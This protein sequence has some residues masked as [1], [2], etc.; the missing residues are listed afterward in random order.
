MIDFTNKEKYKLDGLS[1]EEYA[2]IY[3]TI[4]LFMVKV[5]ERCPNN[6]LNDPSDFF[7][8]WSELIWD[9]QIDSEY[10]YTHDSW[11]NAF[12]DDVWEDGIDEAVRAYRNGLL[13]I[14]KARK[15]FVEKTRIFYSVLADE[16]VYLK[17]FSNPAWDEKQ[18]VSTSYNRALLISK[19]SI[20]TLDK[21]FTEIISRFYNQIY[22]KVFDRII[23]RTEST[24]GYSKGKSCRLLLYKLDFTSFIFH[25]YPINED[26]V[27]QYKLAT[28]EVQ[29]ELVE[30]KYQEKSVE[31]DNILQTKLL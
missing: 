16:E 19:I 29:K 18:I 14:E 7:P 26:E 31:I 10:C 15:L 3:T 5:P 23:V 1:N 8:M 27:N 21:V 20:D 25:V 13:W 2:A 11:E 24:T 6:L 28:I 17:H 4:N 30:G 9:H 22:Y 12:S